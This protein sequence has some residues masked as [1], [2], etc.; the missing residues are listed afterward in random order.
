MQEI[1]DAL[2]RMKSVLR[3]RP[4]AGVHDDAPATARWEHGTRVVASHANGAR[5][6]TDMPGELG[7]SGDQVSPGWLFRAGLASCATT[8]IAMNAAA[9]GIELTE[10]EVKAT[11]RSDARG[12]LGMADAEGAMVFAG[13]SDIE[14]HV[15]IRAKGVAPERLRALV[16]KSHRCSPI[17]SAVENAVPVK[18]RIDAEA[19]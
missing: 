18:L 11:S 19:A 15:R 12:L 9:E 10:L 3:R 14:M 5:V 8:C 16:E 4:S 7:G 2:E 13:P 17:P 6:L 1:A